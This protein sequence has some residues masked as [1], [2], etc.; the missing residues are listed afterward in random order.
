MPTI[1]PIRATLGT[2]CSQGIINAIIEEDQTGELAGLPFAE[3]TTES[4]QMIGQ[5]ITSY[6]PRRN[7]FNHGLVN[8]IGMMRLYYMMWKN[9][10]SD[11]KQ[12]KLEMGET[13]EEIWNGLAEVFPYDPEV[14]ETRVLKR[15]K[16]EVSTAFHSINYQEVYKITISTKELKRAFLSLQGMRDL[17]ETKIASLAR[18]ASYDE[19]M[20]MKYL[21]AVLLLNGK[22]KTASIPAITK[23]TADDVVTAVSE[24]TNLF[25]FASDE[26][27]MAGVENVTPI[28]N[29][30]IFESAKANAYLKVNSLAVA[31]NVEYVKFLG[32]VKMFD[33]LGKFNWKR[34]AKLMAN[35]SGFRQFSS[36]EIA[37]L[38]SIQLIACD[39]N[40]I[41][42]YDSVFDMEEP[43]RNGEGA[44]TNY[45]LQV[46]QIYS[47]SPFH[48][49][50]AYT[51]MTPAVT[52][53]S[54]TPATAS[55]V[56]GSSVAFQANV[57]T[58]GFGSSEVVWEISTQGVAA[59]TVIGQ[60]GV[61]RVG[62]D[63]TKTT[64]TVTCTSV[65]DD[66]KSATATVTVAAK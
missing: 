46:E 43:F 22:I 48:N 41:Q 25:Q 29:L 24:T 9:P 33:S 65:A 30:I 7:A 39:R 5:E 38:E 36:D 27:N 50:I 19:F 53:I 31:F 13:V 42:I 49:C 2:Y 23:T 64:I 3:N 8:L 45:F 32:Q 35:D 59:D 6:A 54:I 52:A 16:G 37:A 18:S 40:F 55:A 60:D 61:L 28:D 15:A 56:K 20:M 63:E 47:A 1:P 12:G 34:M 4:I 11:L 10:W 44:F 62:A 21:F 66:T 51:T 17:V 14:S 26:Y 58:T 57:T